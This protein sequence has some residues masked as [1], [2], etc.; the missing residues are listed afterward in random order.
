MAWFHIFVPP[1]R[2]QLNPRGLLSS[3]S[4]CPA[5]CVVLRDREKMQPRSDL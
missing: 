4:L 3:V 1:F 5:R 2:V